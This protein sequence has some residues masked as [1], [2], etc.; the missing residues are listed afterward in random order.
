MFVKFT[1]GC[2]GIINTQGGPEGRSLVVYPCDLNGDDC[3]EPLGLTWR[4]MSDKGHEPLPPEKAVEMI[5]DLHRLLRDGYRFR[6]VR[7]L[8]AQ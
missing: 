4:D 3:W 2:I 5:D 7:A 6:K 1:C 8:L